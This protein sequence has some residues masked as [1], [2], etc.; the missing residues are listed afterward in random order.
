MNERKRQEHDA[1]IRKHMSLTQKIQSWLTPKKDETPRPNQRN[2]YGQDRPAGDVEYL[3]RSGKL[4]VV[5]EGPETAP[6]EENDLREKE[7]PESFL[8]RTFNRQNVKS[9]ALKAAIGGTAATITKLATGT[10]LTAVVPFGAPLLIGFAGAGLGAMAAGVAIKTW[11]N[12]D[13]EDHKNKNIFQRLVHQAS[14]ET[15]RSSGVSAAIGMATFGVINYIPAF[16]DIAAW[17]SDAVA[18]LTEAVQSNEMSVMGPLNPIEIGTETQQSVPAEDNSTNTLAEQ[19][20][21]NEQTQ[22]QLR[23]NIAEGAEKVNAIEL[24][25]EQLKDSIAQKDEAV[26]DIASQLEQI[27]APE[28]SADKEPNTLNSTDLDNNNLSELQQQIDN[29]SESFESLNLSADDQAR[30]DDLT[31][32]L[33]KMME[34]LE[35][36]NQE[37]V[38]SIIEQPSAELEKTVIETPLPETKAE[39]TTETLP[40]ETPESVVLDFKIIS[41]QDTL[42]K[43]AIAY[44]EENFP[45]TPINKETIWQTIDAYME[46]PENEHAL[47]NGPHIIYTGDTVFSPP[48][49]AINFESSPSIDVPTVQDKAPEVFLLEDVDAPSNDEGIDIPLNTESLKQPAQVSFFEVKSPLEATELAEKSQFETPASNDNDGVVVSLD[50]FRDTSNI[51][52]A[53]VNTTTIQNDHVDQGVEIKKT[54]IPDIMKILD[55]EQDIKMDSVNSNVSVT[56]VVALQPS[57][58][59]QVTFNEA[60]FQEKTGTLATAHDASNAAEKT[61]E[62]VKIPKIMELTPEDKASLGVQVN[63]PELLEPTP[64]GGVASVN[65][66]STTS[67]IP[68]NL[69]QAHSILCSDASFAEKKL[70]FEAFASNDSYQFDSA[71]C[72]NG[73]ELNR[74]AIPRALQ[75]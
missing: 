32:G 25:Q 72:D 10:A 50:E 44:L 5:F 43:I 57:S 42:G 12:K 9:F 40:V 1:L 16:D 15:I 17:G 35:L 7:I 36:L 13:N 14:Q 24:K 21:A 51:N 47:R 59:G 74:T 4:H 2:E 62:K 23:D 55:G 3:N 30:L 39:V 18:K 46:L 8:S 67:T 19:I 71:S 61:S 31:T 27:E 58:A 49:D 48:T 73:T 60:V 34:Q 37:N 45:D 22:E 56:N 54:N 28:N 66:P 53:D 52:G 26:A 41:S 75:L 64:E 6:L 68:A 70:A 33:A 69:T 38:P 63:T 11:T 29:I 20:I 65:N